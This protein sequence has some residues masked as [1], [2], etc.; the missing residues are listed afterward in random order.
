MR[1]DFNLISRVDKEGRR[2]KKKPAPPNP[3]QSYPPHPY[4]VQPDRPIKKAASEGERPQPLP[5]G[6]AAVPPQQVCPPAPAA[7]AAA[8]PPT[9]ADS[10]TSD[11]QAT[12]GASASCGPLRIDAP[13]HP[14]TAASCGPTQ[15]GPVI[16]T[17]ADV[18][19]EPSAAA[20]R[21]CWSEQP[22]PKSAAAV[23][24]DPRSSSSAV[25]CG[26][27]R[28]GKLPDVRENGQ[29]TALPPPGSETSTPVVPGDC[30][31]YVGNCI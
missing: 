3:T 10:G 14:A 11:H 27:S 13:R 8:N 31:R 15:P 5:R 22:D 7:G 21:S 9:A 20:A 25:S 23:C 12:G 18:S 1:F 17:A 6:H 19:F 29:L 2:R 26:S 16:S 24:S 28:P 4:P 30:E